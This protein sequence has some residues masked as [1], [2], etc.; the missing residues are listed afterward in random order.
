M[1]ASLSGW[2]RREDTSVLSHTH[3]Q[4]LEDPLPK[5]H[6]SRDI[7]VLLTHSQS[8]TQTHTHVR[9]AIHDHSDTVSL[10]EIGS[11]GHQKHTGPLGEDVSA[12]WKE[13]GG[14]KVVGG[15]VEMGSEIWRLRERCVTA[16]PTRR[17]HPC[18][19]PSQPSCLR[20]IPLSRDATL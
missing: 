20:E 18:P 6:I 8:N 15:Q 3:T 10:I 9:Q 4:F 13:K 5:M 16:T 12:K 7:H 11:P 17:W 19:H 1:R 2:E 14:W